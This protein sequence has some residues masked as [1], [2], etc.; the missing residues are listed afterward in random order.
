MHPSHLKALVDLGWLKVI[1]CFPTGYV[2]TR[3]GYVELAKKLAFSPG[4]SLDRYSHM[5]LE[6]V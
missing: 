2:F 1:F 5:K 3:G 6:E 4:V